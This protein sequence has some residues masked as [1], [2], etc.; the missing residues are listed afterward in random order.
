M[1][2]TV[3]RGWPG[4]SNCWATRCLN[5]PD[6]GRLRANA[7]AL[8]LWDDVAAR[9][10]DLQRVSDTATGAVARGAALVQCL[11]PS[12]ALLPAVAAVCCVAGRRISITRRVAAAGRVDGAQRFDG[13][14]PGASRT[15][16][17]YGAVPL[18]AGRLWPCCPQGH[19]LLA[20]GLCWVQHFANQPFVS[21]SPDDRYRRQIDGTLPQAGVAASFTLEN[22]APCHCAPWCS[23]GWGWPSSTRSALAM[24]GSGLVVRG[25]GFSVPFSINA[26][27]PLYRQP[28]PK[29]GRCCHS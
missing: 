1:Q 7:R 3:S 11:P 9:L 26:L 10:Q 19:P 16:P 22:P 21:L 20:P 6:K 25:L 24:A 18:D 15:A 27:L 2:P 17:G 14:G 12:P 13:P 8:A 29:R 5:A 23:K 28:C 4:W